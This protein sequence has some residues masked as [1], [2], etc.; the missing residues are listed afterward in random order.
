M[1]DRYT[2][3]HMEL[4]RGEKIDRYTNINNL[5]V[6]IIKQNEYSFVLAITVCFLHVILIHPISP[7]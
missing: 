1:T 5:H 3:R 4:E 6:K 2:E 7:E